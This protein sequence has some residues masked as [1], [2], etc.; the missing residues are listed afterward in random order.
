MCVS[1]CL[2]RMRYVQGACPRWRS[3]LEVDSRAMKIV[4]MLLGYNMLRNEPAIVALRDEEQTLLRRS[5]PSQCQTP[6]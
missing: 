1:V 3:T 2:V 5:L 4:S 6:T